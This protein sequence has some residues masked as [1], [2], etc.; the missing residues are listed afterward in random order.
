MKDKKL[1][2]KFILILFFLFVF[3]FVVDYLINYFY[4]VEASSKASL[5]ISIFSVAAALSA[6]I[7]AFLFYNNWKAQTKFNRVT[8]NILELQKVLHDYVTELKFLRNRIIFPHFRG[9]FPNEDDYFNNLK[10]LLDQKV[11]EIS[12]AER[13]KYDSYKLLSIL[14]ND[15]HGLSKSLQTNTDQLETLINSIY[16]DIQEF[17]H[18]YFVFINHYYKEDSELKNFLKTDEYKS[19]TYKIS[20]TRETNNV[21]KTNLKLALTLK[22]DRITPQT[23]SQISKYIH[24]IDALCTLLLTNYELNFKH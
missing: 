24:D 23:T 22:E 16:T 20:S 13:L 12:L 1:Y 11:S 7:T 15:T 19:L 4:V 9:K 2:I 5:L 6:P 18:N 14:R 10:K 17:K 21:I 3:V 8:A